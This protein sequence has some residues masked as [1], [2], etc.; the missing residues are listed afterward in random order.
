MMSSFWNPEKQG[1]LIFST[2]RCGT[3][4][5]MRALGEY[6]KSI[7]GPNYT[8]ILLGEFHKEP[9]EIDFNY[10]ENLKSDYTIGIV[11][12]SFTKFLLAGKNEK[13]EKWHVAHLT[14]NDKVSHF[15]SEYVW[16]HNS[17]EFYHHG[18]TADN[19][20]KFK[21]NK[22]HYE[23]SM[24]LDW[25]KEDLINYHL[26]HA[27]QIDYSDL[28]LLE[29]SRIKWRP[30]YYDLQLSDLFTNYIEIENLLKTFKI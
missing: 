5:L 14:R 4:F 22:L 29:T 24:V 6:I 15:I 19:F 1:T 17:I 12:S 3:H 10:L 20:K 8:V 25:L 26:P 9:G 18:Q 7:N 2:Y 11:N 28:K 13:L 30:N 21:N 16:R 23:L 27:V